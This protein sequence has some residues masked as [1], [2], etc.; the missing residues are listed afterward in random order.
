MTRIITVLVALF[1]VAL[2][3]VYFQ[4]NNLIK[5]G[6]ETAGPDLLQVDVGVEAV[7]LSLF[8][9]EAVVRGLSIGQPDGF[10]EGPMA[11]LGQL[12]MKVRP[13]T[14]LSNH[15]IIDHIVIDAPL[16]DA[17]LKSGTSNFQALQENIAKMLPAEPA[18][19]P[20]E[21]VLTIHRMEVSSPR[22]RLDNEGMIDVNEDITLAGFTLTDLGTDEQGLAPGEIARHVMDVLE[23]QIAKAMIEAGMKNQLKDLG[24]D[25]GKSLDDDTRQ[26]LEKGIGGVID[27]LKKKDKTDDGGNR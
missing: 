21:T 16:L 26:K 19:A 11:S 8:S 22:V 4:L 6:A 7:D 2:V 5:T 9:G 23:P 17:R 1:V 13:A 20:S 10:G 12:D 24:K 15:I 25:L 3:V 27:L 14:L 18:A